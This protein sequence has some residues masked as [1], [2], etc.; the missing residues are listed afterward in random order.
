MY[1]HI[2]VRTM[3]ID[4]KRRAMLSFELRKYAVKWYGLVYS[5]YMLIWCSVVIFRAIEVLTGYACLSLRNSTPI[6]IL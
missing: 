5:V 2:H 3:C 4:S 1:G 6:Q